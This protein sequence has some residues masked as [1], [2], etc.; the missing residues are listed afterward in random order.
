MPFILKCICDS[1][2]VGSHIF[3][4]Q[5]LYYIYWLIYL[6]MYPGYHMSNLQ[7]RDLYLLYLL[8]DLFTNVPRVSY[9]QFTDYISI[10]TISI[11][12]FIY[13]S[14]QGIIFLIYKIEIYIYY[15]YWLIYLQMYLWYHTSNLYT[16][17]LYLLYLLTDGC[18]QG[19]IYPIYRL[20]IYIYYIY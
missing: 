2:C 7:T 10:S 4:L 12:W 16:R 13:R 18:T 9:V 17:D 8:T 15:I 3:Y 1:V 19:L 6:L 11:N 5:N 14:T 20:E